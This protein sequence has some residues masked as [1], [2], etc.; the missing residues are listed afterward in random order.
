MALLLQ[1]RVQR[2]VARASSLAEPGVW[3]YPNP[4]SQR[5]CEESLASQPVCVQRRLDDLCRVQRRSLT[6]RRG[7]S[8]QG[9]RALRAVPIQHAA[10][11]IGASS[12]LHHQVAFRS[13]GREG[14]SWIISIIVSGS[15]RRRETPALQAGWFWRASSMPWPELAGGL[16]RERSMAWR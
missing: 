11:T 1:L 12:S 16:S 8:P 3:V 5:R 7:V 4:C 10:A 13:L 15:S 14:P 6:T 2:V 9:L